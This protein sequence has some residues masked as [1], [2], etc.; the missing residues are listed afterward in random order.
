MTKACCCLQGLVPCVLDHAAAIT[1]VLSSAEVQSSLEMLRHTQKLLFDNRVPWEFDKRT[2]TSK[3]HQIAKQVLATLKDSPM[4]PDISASG[5]DL[6]PSPGPAD[7]KAQT[8]DA[9]PA[10]PEPATQPRSHTHSRPSGEEQPAGLRKPGRSRGSERPPPG[11]LSPNPGR[12]LGFS[13]DVHRRSLERPERASRPVPT[14]ERSRSASSL[15]SRGTYSPG[16]RSSGRP[17]EKDSKGSSQ[18]GLT[19]H[20]KQQ[21]ALLHRRMLGDVIAAAIVNSFLL[22]LSLLLHQSQRPP[23]AIA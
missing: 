6:P 5:S 13:R 8:D 9:K 20:H 16:P 15:S 17:V 12:P 1:R 18:V 11:P 14:M 22:L 10:T 23:P 2:F 21:G 4:V 7:T 3:T 19:W